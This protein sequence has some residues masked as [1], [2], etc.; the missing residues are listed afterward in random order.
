MLI[1]KEFLIR[2]VS[3]VPFKI[4]LFGNTSLNIPESMLILNKDISDRFKIPLIFDIV[5]SKLLCLCESH[6]LV[7]EKEGYHQGFI[8][9]SSLS[10]EDVV[11]ASLE[12]QEIFRF[13]TLGISPPSKYSSKTYILKLVTP[14]AGGHLFPIPCPCYELNLE[15]TGDEFNQCS[16]L[17]PETV[18]RVSF[19]LV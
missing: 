15:L 2:E 16:L 9:F 4:V 12:G 17:P 6:E 14:M 5:G 19:Q 18:F 8:E 11:I 1:T 3:A 7:P 13:L 10:N